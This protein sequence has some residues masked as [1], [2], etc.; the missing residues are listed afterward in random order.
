[1]IDNC[2]V[3]LALI[4]LEFTWSGYSTREKLSSSVIVIFVRARM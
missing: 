4:S 2:N 3:L 1:M